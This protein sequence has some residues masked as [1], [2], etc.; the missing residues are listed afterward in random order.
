MGEPILKSDPTPRPSEGLGRDGRE[1]I[2]P[3][4]LGVVP[5]LVEP[6][7]SSVWKLSCRMRALSSSLFVDILVLRGQRVQVS[8]DH[9]KTFNLSTIKSLHST[10][11]FS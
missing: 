3:P 4:G 11:R 5:K 2:E 9:W 6:A 8:G 7:P 1:D 10:F